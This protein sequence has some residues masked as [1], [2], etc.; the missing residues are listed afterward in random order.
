MRFGGAGWRPGSRR[1]RRRD[2]APDRST[3]KGADRVFIVILVV[4]VLAAVGLM[5]L[6]GLYAS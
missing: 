1:N 4:F 6:L 3:E 2:G 5:L